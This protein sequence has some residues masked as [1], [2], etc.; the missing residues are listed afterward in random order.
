MRDYNLVAHFRGFIN[1]NP[2]AQLILFAN[3]ESDCV[4]GFR[5]NSVLNTGVPSKTFL[6]R[7]ALNR[8]YQYKEYNRR[9]YIATLHS[10]R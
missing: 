10:Q 8:M 4:P 6:Q 2:C 1:R 7:L 5:K 3:N 9:H